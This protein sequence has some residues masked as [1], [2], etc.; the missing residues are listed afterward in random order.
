MLLVFSLTIFC[1]LLLLLTAGLF[2]RFWLVIV[3]VEEQSMLPTL[4]PGD[5]LIVARHWPARWLRNGQIVLVWPARFA[6]RPALFKETP[7]IKRIVALGGETYQAEDQ[8]GQ[9]W[10]I[11]PGQLFVRGDH[12]GHSVDSLVWGPLPMQQVAG[13]VLT[14]LPRRAP[15]PAA[16][17]AHTRKA[18]PAERKGGHHA[19]E[20]ALDS[21]QAHWR[22]SL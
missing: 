7:Y 14:T 10:Q 20:A 13:V 3:T 5:R 18:P 12:H 2:I 4:A 19:D 22:G 1:F 11:P 6:T 21:P 16:S 17:D 9:L 15:A 8:H